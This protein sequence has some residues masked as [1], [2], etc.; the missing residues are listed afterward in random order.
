MD[1][2]LERLEREFNLETI[3]TTPSVVYKVGLTSGEEIEVSSPNEM[4]E[5]VKISY[6]KEPYIYTNII[7]PTEF[8]G[9]IMTLCQNKRCIY[10]TT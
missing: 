3:A 1:I 10:D 5:K 4:P 9:P 7:S 6:I 8:I 2:I